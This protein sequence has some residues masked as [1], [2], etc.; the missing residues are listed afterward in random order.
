MDGKVT[1]FEIPGT[2]RVLESDQDGSLY[3][4]AGC[5]LMRWDS[6]QLETLLEVDCDNSNR[7]F[8]LHA[9]DITFDSDGNLW[10]GDAHKLAK[11]DGEVWEQY[12]ISALRVAFSSD[13]T[14]WALGW[15]GR[16]GSQCCLTNLTP[17]GIVTY[18]WSADIPQEIVRSLFAANR[19]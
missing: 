11:F 13:E 7:P 4:G 1:Q 9:I 19:R 17:S 18:S 10:V 3:I 6:D 12:D 14:L 15:N 16:A 5:G 8:S 2:I